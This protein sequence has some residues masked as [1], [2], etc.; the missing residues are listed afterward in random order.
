M[1]CAATSSPREIN[2]AAFFQLGMN[3][4]E[5]PVWENDRT[6]GEKAWQSFGIEDR[7]GSESVARLG[8]F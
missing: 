4:A 5:L 6:P 7:G 8:R 3:R 1:T 2:S